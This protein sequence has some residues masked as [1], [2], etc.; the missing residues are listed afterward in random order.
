M[1]GALSNKREKKELLYDETIMGRKNRIKIIVGRILFS[2]PFIL[3]LIILL[4]DHPLLIK[5]S[6]FS[7]FLFPLGIIIIIMINCI[8][9]MTI[10]PLKLYSDGISLPNRALK[11]IFLRQ[12]TIIRYDEMKK[13]QVFSDNSFK[14]YLMTGNRKWVNVPGNNIIQHASVIQIISKKIPVE[15]IPKQS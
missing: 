12:E 13:I 4:I 5:I 10:S 8:L 1:E 2:L 6:S 9:I 11:D 3:L 7:I 14:I 15:K